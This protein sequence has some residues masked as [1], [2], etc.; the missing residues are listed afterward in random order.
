M[1][2]HKSEAA[3]QII[4]DKMRLGNICLFNHNNPKKALTYYENA[5]NTATDN[6]TKA[7]IAWSMGEASSRIKLS[8]DHCVHAIKYMTFFLNNISAI[9]PRSV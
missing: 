2:Q 4:V 6:A 8:V 3:S 9:V 5:F 1:N 7:L